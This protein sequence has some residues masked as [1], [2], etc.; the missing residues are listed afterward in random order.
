MKL[1]PR[2]VSWGP[3]NP[4]KIFYIIGFS[5]E[6][7]GLFA[8][9]KAALSH[10]L[11]AVKKGYIP[12]V[13][14]RDWENQYIKKNEIGVRNSWEL[15]FNQPMEYGLE[16]VSNSQNIILSTNT[17]F[18][19]FRYV[20]SPRFMNKKYSKKLNYISSQYKKYIHFNKETELYCQNELKRLLGNNKV[21]GILCRGTDY[22]HRRPLNH[23][24]QPDPIEVINKA[25]ELYPRLKYDKI[26]LAT[27]D[28]DIFELF[29]K[30]F[31]EI[32]ITN[33]QIL[34]KL[35]DHIQYLSEIDTA[36]RHDEYLKGME[37]LSSLYILSQCN[38]F[39]GGRTSGSQGVYFMSNGF[40]YDYTWDLGYY[41]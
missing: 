29:H 33:G 3:Q 21:L 38:F 16:D 27:E 25:K 37:Y 6:S 31:G 14:L 5:C 19:R 9:V 15:F 18:P 4:D 10:I 30:N 26:Y 7:L 17:W 1:H 22:I 28:Q 11:Y 23:P 8:L 41:T 36:H 24:I 2:K 39:I 35:S 12:V 40:E 13:N 20:I 34:Y 32:L